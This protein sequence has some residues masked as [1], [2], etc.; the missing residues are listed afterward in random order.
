ML[1]Q[2]LA[3]LCSLVLQPL[4]QH[5][6]APKAATPWLLAQQALL[7]LLVL[8]LL[9]GHLAAQPAQL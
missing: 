2:L 4:Q 9:P 1:Q 6:A 3:Q 5:Q 8:V 7:L